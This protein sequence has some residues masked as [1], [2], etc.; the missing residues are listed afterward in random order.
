MGQN[1]T[2]AR[3]SG[4]GTFVSP[5]AYHVT[6][7][8]PVVV[9]QFNPII[10]Q[11]SNDA[12]TLIPRQA[13]GMDYIVDR[14]RDREPVRISGLPLPDNSIPDH[15][16]ITIIP[17]EDNT[18]VTVTTDHAIKAAAGDTGL[19]IAATPKGGTLNLTPV[20]LHGR[21]PRDRDDDRLGRRVRGRGQR[22]AGRRLH[23]HL[24][25]EP[26]SRS[27]CSPRTS[28]APGFGGAPN[29]VYPPDW[30]AMN[31]D[32]ICCTDH[33]EEQLFP[34]T[35]L[36][37]EFAVAR[38]PIRSTHADLGRAGHHARGRHRRRHRRS[39]PT[40]RRRSTRSR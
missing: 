5:H 8:G 32:D 10:Q 16:A 26:T 34:V 36:G 2:Y 38:S 29:V 12:S 9:Y 13:L 6:T 17:I 1:G 39:R 35:A 11:Y 20:P 4:S 21:E 27:S 23:R 3:N 37:R 30:D 22:R 15:G 28:A 18:N 33:L 31:G 40:C 19:P 7:T 24:H 14:L 25:Q